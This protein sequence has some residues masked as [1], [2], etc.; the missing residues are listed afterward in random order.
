MVCD[1]VD[2]GVGEQQSGPYGCENCHAV[3]VRWEDR[4]SPELDA[5]EKKFQ[6]WKGQKDDAV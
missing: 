6:V 2:I 3:A 4:N 1:M 5:E